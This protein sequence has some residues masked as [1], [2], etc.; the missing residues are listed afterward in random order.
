M[1]GSGLIGAEQTCHDALM[2]AYGEW[3]KLPMQ[4]PDDMRDFGNA[5]HAIQNLLAFR[6]VRRAYPDYWP[7]HSNR[8]EVNPLNEVAK[9]ELN[10]L[11]ERLKSAVTSIEN[12]LGLNDAPAAEP[13][14]APAAAPEAAPA[15]EEKAAV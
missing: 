12:L 13:E 14:A 1:T 7:D 11:L 4:H 6:I 2:K 5:V 10:A 15:E 8:R 9:T 3:L